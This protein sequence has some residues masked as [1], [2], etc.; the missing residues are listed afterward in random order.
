MKIQN[1]SILIS[2]MLLNNDAWF[3]KAV[4][5]IAEHNEKGTIG[6]VIN[7]LFGRNFNE[8]IEFQQS[9]SYPLFAGGPVKNDSLFTIHRRPEMVDDSIVI[10]GSICMGG[11]FKQALAFM[12]K[13]I[14][15]EED[16]KLFIGYAGWDAGQLD[17]E[18]KEG[19]WLPVDAPAQ[20]VFFSQSN[21]LWEELFERKTLLSF[22]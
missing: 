1:G 3:S 7:K 4:I 10:I 19:S 17:A 14:I 22:N 8:L 21:F 5:F 16:I 20:I 12:N 13:K 11:N 6:F 2:S 15:S 18:I 9:P